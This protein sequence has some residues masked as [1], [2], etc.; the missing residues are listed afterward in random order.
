M[1]INGE[2]PF[3]GVSKRENPE[4]KQQEKGADGETVRQKSG[5]DSV[6]LTAS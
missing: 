4:K 6:E 2:V 1:D 3:S 5:T